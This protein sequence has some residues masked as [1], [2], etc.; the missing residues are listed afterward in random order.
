MCARRTKRIEYS[1][2]L[3][4]VPK[5][6]F[7]EVTPKIPGLNPFAIETVS[8]VWINDRTK[9][10]S[11]MNWYLINAENHE[12]IKSGTIKNSDSTSSGSGLYSAKRSLKAFIKKTFGIDDVQIVGVELKSKGE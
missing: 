6:R 4:V 2:D 8:P 5:V 9:S 1:H 7:F 10:Y 3:G 12:L 11:V